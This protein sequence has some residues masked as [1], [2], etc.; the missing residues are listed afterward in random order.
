MGATERSGVESN[1]EGE[2]EK[3][4]NTVATGVVGDT[5]IRLTI[6][7]EPRYVD[8]SFRAWNITTS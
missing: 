5:I 4:E 2:G 7:T 1:G 8:D 3:I 6:A